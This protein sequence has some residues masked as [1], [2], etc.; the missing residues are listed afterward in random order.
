[1][2]EVFDDPILSAYLTDELG[3]D[4]SD[5]MAC[6]RAIRRLCAERIAEWRDHV[7]Q[8]VEQA[9]ALWDSGERP[10]PKGLELRPGVTREQRF[11]WLVAQ[12]FTSEMLTDVLSVDAAELAEAAGVTRRAAAAF[13]ERFTS[14]W[15]V[16]RGLTLLTGRNEVRQRPLL[17]A[18]DGRAH[19]TSPGNL[20]WALRPAM[21]AS[22]KRDE[23]VFEAYQARRAAK[24]EQ[25]AARYFQHALAPDSLLTNLNFMTPDGNGET[26]LLVRLDD[27]LIIVEAKS[28]VLSDG[29]YQGR[30]AALSR[31]LQ[32]LLGKSSQQTSRLRHALRDG[33]PVTFVSRDSG[34]AVEV[35][36]DNVRRLHSVVVTLEDLSP[37]V[38]RPGRLIEADIIDAEATLPWCVNLF[39]LEV[40]AKSTQFP[41][42]LTSYLDARA[43]LDSRA[44]WPGEDDLWMTRLLA[45]L[46]F[47]HIDRE[48]FLVDGRTDLL[49]EQWMLGR[50]APRAKLP[51]ATKKALQRL[52]RERSAGWLRR[53]EELLDHAMKSRRP[54]VVAPVLP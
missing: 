17:G 7:P 39:D 53:T 16:S 8:A 40:I 9:V 6:D 45:R 4:A 28:G 52:S 13:I 15:G 54:N 32:R 30:K 46:N 31:D 33:Q 47:D 22:L 29:A 43:R 3:F 35:D 44:E 34:R 51:K 50:P 23:K 11:W 48:M 5:A 19:P 38:M 20:L 42:Q 36:L 25:D 24:T 14:Q 10:I 12:Y 26:D 18:A 1:M 27:L 2:G 21:E 37:I 49:A 41:A